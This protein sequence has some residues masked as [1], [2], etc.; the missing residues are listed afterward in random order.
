M[1]AAIR[2]IALMMKAA[3]VS[4]MLVN[5]YQTTRLN[6]LEDMET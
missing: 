3:S 1:L 5:F 2:A 4:E 6:K